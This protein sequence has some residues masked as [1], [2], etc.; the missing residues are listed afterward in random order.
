M[1]KYK[2][3]LPPTGTTGAAGV[4]GATGPTGP[5]AIGIAEFGYI[6]N[7]Y[8][9]TV[10]I[11]NNIAFDSN[12]I[13]TSGIKHIPGSDEIIVNTAGYYEVTFSV[14]KL[15]PSQFAIFVN[16]VVVPETVY[17]SVSGAERYEGQAILAL[18]AGDILN[19]RNH[20]SPS[21]VT[22]QTLEGGSRTNVNASIIIKKL[23]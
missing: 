7:V 17:G 5:A 16:D 13:F 3:T 11:E 18:A 1:S 8:P 22:L 14:S 21:T 2:I 19:L 12:R 6:F 15:E 10:P 4:T 9:Q 20:T 23:N